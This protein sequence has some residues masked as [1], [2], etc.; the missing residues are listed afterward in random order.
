MMDKELV[1]AGVCSVQV[2]GLVQVFGHMVQVGRRASWT[3]VFSWQW[4]EPLV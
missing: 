2:L 3:V 4:K 1:E